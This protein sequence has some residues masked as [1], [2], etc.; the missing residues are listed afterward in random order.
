MFRKV[1][2]LFIMM[3]A[4]L[5]INR[6]AKPFTSLYINDVGITF[7]SPN[8]N[9]ILNGESYTNI[10]V[11]LTN[12]G[13]NTQI[14]GIPVQLKVTGRD[15]YLYEDTEVTSESM[16]QYVSKTVDF[17]PDWHVP[18]TDC[19]Y[20][21][22]AWI[23][24]AGD[25][26]PSNDRKTIHI[27]ANKLYSNDVGISSITSPSEFPNVQGGH[28]EDVRVYLKNYG[29]NTQQAGIPV[30][31]K[32]TG[33]ENYLYED[34]DMTTDTLGRDQTLRFRFE[35]DW[36]VPNTDFTYTIE[37]WTELANDEDPSNDKSTVQVT[38]TKNPWNDVGINNIDFPLN[39]SHFKGQTL[40]TVKAY[41]I[42]KGA[43]EQPAGIPVKLKITGP[44]NYIYEDTE[45]SEYTLG[46]N[47]LDYIIYDPGWE[48]PN[49]NFSYTIEI[50]SELTGDED[51]SNDSKTVEVSAI[52]IDSLKLQLLGRASISGDCRGIAI[53]GTHAFVT[54]G[55]G[56]YSADISD[57]FH[58]AIQSKV[59]IG[60]T[61]PFTYSYASDIQ[62]SGNY[63]YITEEWWSLLLGGQGCMRV[64]DISDP[65]KLNE[66][67]RSSELVDYAN[68][69][70]VSGDWAYIA[71]DDGGFCILSISDPTQ[72]GLTSK[73]VDVSDAVWHI[74]VQ[75]NNLYVVSD[76]HLRIYD[77]SG[78]PDA[79][80]L[81][82]YDEIKNGSGVCVSGRYAYVADS[83]FGVHIIDV[84]D[85]ANPTLIS[86]IDTPGYARRVQIAGNLAYV[87]DGVAG[88]R[89]IDVS[90]PNNPSEI[91]YYCFQD[92][93]PTG[94]DGGFLDI[95]VIDDY[96]Y[97]SA[98]IGYGLHV[99]HYGE[100]IAIEDKEGGLIPTEFHLSQNYP[101][102]F[103][104]KTCIEYT[105]PRNCRVTI[106]VFNLLGQKIET[107]VDR[108]H[109]SG[110]Y[111]IDWNAQGLGSGLYFYQLEAEGIYHIRKLL[112]L[113]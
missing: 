98:N 80:L 49:T 99:F 112:I 24:L 61:N 19:T 71:L 48:V 22:E 16:A 100:P 88:L 38:V 40:K 65:T 6:E 110:E 50:K 106:T 72:P 7:H 63:A 79:S 44:G 23:E 96:V 60:N 57:P 108:Q 73:R 32:I 21:I 20:T 28:E 39:G 26:N 55:G 64:I 36:K 54:D 58:P 47:D 101:N 34:T 46:I 113:K 43:N 4:V 84:N 78:A 15:G 5:S 68:A 11:N 56:V 81:G 105:I 102:P 41:L 92:L 94:Q 1:R 10:R 109:Q 53:S 12:W 97:A 31:L 66:I 89:V 91:G 25:E 18:N 103:N 104:L 67:A 85:P 90:N 70:H 87:A 3:I 76:Y 82:T 86:T 35:P 95:E 37:A 17:V 51:A 45:I 107:L 13:T 30:K 69:I 62:I 75:G 111:K 83:E 77:I 42:N 93:N 59:N 52:K 74:F 29:L 2:I 33:P 27:I 9:A 14:S 8:E